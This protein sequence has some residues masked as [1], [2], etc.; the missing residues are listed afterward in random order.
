LDIETSNLDADYGFIITWCI[1]VQGS[2]EI[3]HDEIT[4][5][6]LDKS[7]GGTEDRRV[8]QSLIAAMQTFDLLVTY[9]GTRFDMPYIRTRAL[10]CKVDFP[11]YGTLHHQ[12]CYF[13]AKFKL[14][15]SRNGLD[16]VCR[17][18]LGETE[19]TRVAGDIWRKAA[20]GEKKSIG[21]ILDHN[22]RD[23]RD[24]EKVYDKLIKFSRGQKRSV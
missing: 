3:L 16:Q 21:Y 15:L 4:K 6:D 1:K 23:V 20:R 5:A 14:K 18:I 7:K 22:K 2:D 17:T 9:Y 12:D 13:L 11:E 24:T 8:V 19:K 10:V